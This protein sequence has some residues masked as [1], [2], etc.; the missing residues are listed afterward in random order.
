MS[1]AIRRSA[2][3][4]RVPLADTLDLGPDVWDQ[5]LT[6]SGSSSPFLTW[7]WH[8]ACAAAVA[9]H[10]LDACQA[11]VLRSASGDVEAVFPFRHHPDRFWGVPVTEVGWSFGDLGCPDHL[12]L[13]ASPEAD[14]HALVGALEDVPWL[15]ISL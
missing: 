13:L 6:R 10:E 14:L 5:V 3:A 9:S 8:G 7:A 1:I 11:V 15:W 4:L 12:E 2:A